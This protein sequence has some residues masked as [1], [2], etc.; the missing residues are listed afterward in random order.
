MSRR[1]QWKQVANGMLGDVS[2]ART[3]EEREN[4]PEKACGFCRNFSENAYASDGR[5][6]CKKLKVG[7]D[8]KAVPPVYVMEGEASYTVLFNSDGGKCEHYTRQALIDTSGSEVNDPSYR[9]AHRQ[10]KK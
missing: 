5:G 3:V 9:R 4:V 2:K 8:I 1:S 10:L 7:S 6:Y